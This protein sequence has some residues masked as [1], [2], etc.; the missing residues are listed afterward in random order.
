MK[1]E[2]DENISFAWWNTSLSPSAKSR[3]KEDDLNLALDVID[4]MISVSKIDF[5]ALGEV[6]DDQIELIKSRSEP[7]G[8]DVQVGISNIGRSKFDTCY[9]F[10]TKKIFISGLSNIVSR[11]GGGNLK[12]AQK[13]DLIV[14]NFGAPIHVFASHW[15]SRLWCNENNAERHSLGVR[16]R[17]EIDELIDFYEFDPYIVLL[18]DYN[19]EPFDK[20]LSDQVMATRD[21]NLARKKSYL[22]YNPFWNHLS[23]R[24]YDIETSGSYYYKSGK[25]TQWHTFDQIIF[26]HA[27]LTSTDW[28]LCAKN[29][30]ILNVPGYI[31]VVKNSN[32]IF[33]H[34]PV[35]GKL[36]RAITHG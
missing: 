15:P 30:C 23:A 20:S 35:S 22:L 12:V 24:S 10:N 13:L 9:V 8:Y 6:S 7:L 25:L 21:I 19:D 1:P 31:D 14:E 34:L 28:V 5:I 36:V 11:R 27:F 26:S 29:D 32:S 33:D 2:T 3:A 17:D 18:G 16:L 4:Y